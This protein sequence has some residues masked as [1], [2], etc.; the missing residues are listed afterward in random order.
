MI[1]FLGFLI[2]FLLSECLLDRRE[3]Q[4]PKA[5]SLQNKEAF[6]GY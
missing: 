5:K 3:K 6:G 1:R 4:R 2:S